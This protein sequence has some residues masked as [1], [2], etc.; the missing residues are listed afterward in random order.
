M[1]QTFATVVSAPLPSSKADISRFVQ[2]NLFDLGANRGFMCKLCHQVTSLVGNA[3]RHIKMVHLQLRTKPC[4]FCGAKF[5][6]THHRRDHE[7]VCRQKP[8]DAD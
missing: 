2:E 5:K 3:R 4:Q 1:L 6:L 7:R 8:K